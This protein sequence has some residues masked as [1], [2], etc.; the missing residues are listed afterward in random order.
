ME[1]RLSRYNEPFCELSSDSVHYISLD[2][3]RDMRLGVFDAH[4]RAFMSLP[5]TNVIEVHDHLS[6]S[7]EYHDLSNTR[8]FPPFVSCPI[9]HLDSDDREY[10]DSLFFDSGIKAAG[11]RTGRLRIASEV[12]ACRE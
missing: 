10:L 11:Y 9:Q 8:Y 7:T 3:Q 12:S 4:V 2:C 5:R 1:I 6:G